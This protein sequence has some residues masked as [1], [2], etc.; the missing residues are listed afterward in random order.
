MF[1]SAQNYHI[2]KVH[3]LTVQYQ[4]SFAMKYL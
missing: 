3:T 2:T 4:N 1:L